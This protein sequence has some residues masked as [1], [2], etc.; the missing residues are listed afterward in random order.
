VDGSLL[1]IERGVRGQRSKRDS[2]R[3]YARGRADSDVRSVREKGKPGGS[4]KVKGGSWVARGSN[5][6]KRNLKS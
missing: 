3:T 5:L 6:D 2:S 1:I 4:I